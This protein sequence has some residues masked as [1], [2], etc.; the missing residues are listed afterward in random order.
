VIW[1]CPPANTARPICPAD[2][3]VNQIAPSGPTV[4]FCQRRSWPSMSA[5]SARA[6]RAQPCRVGYLA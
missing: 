6:H 2:G 1:I 4:S 3:S 5:P